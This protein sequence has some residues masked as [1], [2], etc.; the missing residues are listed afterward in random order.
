MPSRLTRRA[1]CTPACR[2][3]D[4]PP[5]ARLELPSLARFTR[6]LPTASSRSTIPIREVWIMPKDR[7]QKRDLHAL[8]AEGMVLCNPRDKEATPSGS[9]RRHR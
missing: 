2:A 5:F 4:L 1:T 9:Y 3:T 8:D 7:R 6:A